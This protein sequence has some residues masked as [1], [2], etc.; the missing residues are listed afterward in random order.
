MW[1]SNPVEVSSLVCERNPSATREVSVVYSSF[2]R[3]CVTI[4]KIQIITFAKATFYPALVVYLE[5][6]M[7]LDGME[8]YTELLQSR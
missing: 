2:K 4:Y 1:S 6:S 7:Y 8:K 3:I 5:R